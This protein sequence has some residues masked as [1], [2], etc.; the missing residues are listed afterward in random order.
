[1]KNQLPPTIYRATAANS[2][3]LTLRVDKTLWY[4]SGEIAAER[5][6]SLNRLVRDLLVETVERRYTQKRA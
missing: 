3:R 6:I 5:G 2:R 4:L 1:M